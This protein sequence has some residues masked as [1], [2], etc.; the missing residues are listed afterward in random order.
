MLLAG[1]G[2]WLY[3][4]RPWQTHVGAPA[5]AVEIESGELV[6]DRER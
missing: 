2:T 5:V 4:A 6:G 1:A 3:F